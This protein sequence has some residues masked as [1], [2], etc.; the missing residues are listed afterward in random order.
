MRRVHGRICREQDMNLHLH[1]QHLSEGDDFQDEW[2]F[3]ES[4]PIEPGEHDVCP[5]GQTPI[6]SYFFIENGNQ[7]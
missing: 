5:C 4:R 3:V 6:Q 1:L 2:V 7:W